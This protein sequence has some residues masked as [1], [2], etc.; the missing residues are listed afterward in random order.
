M[1][2]FVAFTLFFSFFEPTRLQW[3][4]G[5]RYMVSMIPF[6]FLLTAAVLIRM[7]KK[8]AY[9]LAVFSFAA[10]WCMSMI[11]HGVGVPEESMLISLKIFLLE[12]FQLPWLN[13]LSKMGTQYVPFLELET[14][15]SL[16]FFVLCAISIYICW[17][18][19][20]YGAKLN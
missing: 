1:L 10:S 17:R 11:R 4:S 5:I 15:S 8:V 20:N 14:L 7:P 13:T 2:L 19:K 18:F 6:L 16:P 3:V 9:G 12:G